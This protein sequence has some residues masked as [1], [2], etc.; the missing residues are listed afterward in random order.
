MENDI[1]AKGTNYLYYIKLNKINTMTICFVVKYVDNNQ[2]KIQKK[3]S[4]DF[5]N[6]MVN[7]HQ[8]VNH[9]QMVNDHQMVNHHQMVSHISKAQL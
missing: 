9:H 3:I 1:D 5:I 7:D 8:M 2:K 4:Q 6:Q